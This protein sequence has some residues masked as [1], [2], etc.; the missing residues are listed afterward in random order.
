MPQEE[1]ILL[2]MHVRRALDNCF[3]AQIV[4]EDYLTY[5]PIL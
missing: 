5:P 2:L 4:V 3:S 1:P